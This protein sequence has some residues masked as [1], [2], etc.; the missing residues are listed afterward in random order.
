MINNLIDFSVKNKFIIILIYVLLIFT[1]FFYLKK[2]PIDAIPD[3][4]DNRV[5]VYTK[6]E[7]KNPKVIND[8]ITYPL[9]SN[10]QGLA[11]IKSI[12]AFSEFGYSMIYLIFKDDIDI[13]F[14]RNRVIERLTYIKDKLPQNVNPVVGPDATGVGHVLWYV[15]EGKN[16]DLQELRTLQDWYIK[17]Q[18]NSID[19]VSEVAS[20][21]GFVKEYQIDIIPD[22]LR[23]Y[24]IDIKELQE[25]INSNNNYFS[26]NNLE[27][28][29]SEY[30]IKVSTY[31]KSIKDIENI[32]VKYIDGLPIYIKNIAKV[33][34][35]PEQRRGILE[36]N[37]NGEVVGGIIVMR[38]GENTNEVTS[39][40]KNK[41][42]EISKSLPNDI[43]IK[44]AYDRSDLI[45]ESVNTLKSA[46]K[47]EIILVSIII[48]LFLLHIRSTFIVSITLP[49]TVLISMILIYYFKINLNIMS[50]LF[51]WCLVLKT[52]L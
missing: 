1:S 24:D 34:I 40:V 15:L 10:F 37:G 49:I 29:S 27:I 7:G 12:R 25:A 23:V 21:G 3:L 32:I 28:N 11:G 43:K 47:E 8:Q 44:I 42:K 38:Y 31:L 36:E 13:Y 26:G 33:Q 48:F 14:A 2:I 51:H 35:G 4:S 50:F 52:V 5:I 9:S 16:Y 45:N 20:I 30:I 46:L 39:K 17:Y 41:I 19:G 22:K 6:W 18:L